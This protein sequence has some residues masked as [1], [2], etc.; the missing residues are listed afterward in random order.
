MHNKDIL[1]RDIKPANMLYKNDG[2]VVIADFG[3]AKKTNHNFTTRV[4]TL[5]YR[6]PELL[7]GCPKY[8][9]KIDLWSIG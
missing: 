9:G 8:D 4:V 6:A 1:H 2:T 5:W 3:L 7:L